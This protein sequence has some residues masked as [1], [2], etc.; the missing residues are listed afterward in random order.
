M[1]SLQHRLTVIVCVVSWLLVGL[2][3]PVLHELTDPA[4][5][6]R[7]GTLILLGVFGLLG[8]AASWSLL[9]AP[10]LLVRRSRSRSSA[11]AAP[12]R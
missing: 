5:D 11:A 9:R 10:D 1:T 4:H 6:A 7:P 12:D 2:H 3:A 8:I